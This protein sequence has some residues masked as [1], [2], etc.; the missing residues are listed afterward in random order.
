MIMEQDILDTFG[1]ANFGYVW[2]RLDTLGYVF[3]DTRQNILD[4]HFWIRTINLQRKT[5]VSKLRCF[6]YDWILLLEN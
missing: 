3:L 6:G 4:T 1:Y 2:I 5:R